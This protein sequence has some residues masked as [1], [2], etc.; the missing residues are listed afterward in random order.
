MHPR[1][2]F[3]PTIKKEIIGNK[4]CVV[5]I[6]KHHDFYL[7]LKLAS[8][9]KKL[10]ENESLNE[11]LSIDGPKYPGFVQVKRLIKALEMF[12]EGEQEALG[13]EN[14]QKEAELKKKL[15]AEEKDEEY[16][17]AENKKEE[18]K[19]DHKLNHIVGM[20]EMIKLVGKHPKRN[21]KDAGRGL[22]QVGNA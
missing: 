3:G 14:E 20:D 13:L 7:R 17:E 4:K 6:I 2:F 1:E 10:K 11:F 8:I 22:S 18:L 12:A 5:E 21:Q 15:E 16:K 9:R 19:S